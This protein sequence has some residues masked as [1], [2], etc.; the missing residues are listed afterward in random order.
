M[1]GS[2]FLRAKLVVELDDLF[3]VSSESVTDFI[4][5]GKGGEISIDRKVDGSVAGR[6]VCEILDFSE[7]KADDRVEVSKI[8][9]TKPLREDGI[10]DVG[11][12]T[13]EETFLV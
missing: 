6:I 4:R 5:V 12:E 11:P 8:L 9:V 3:I 13:V 10:R 2:V 1:W 7:D